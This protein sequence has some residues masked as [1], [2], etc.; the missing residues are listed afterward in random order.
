MSVEAVN[1]VEDRLCVA[2]IAGAHGVRGDVRIKSFT[3]N[4]EGLAAYDG[5]TIFVSHEPFASAERMKESVTR[6]E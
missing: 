4:P 1:M 2:V 3:A 5:T 6:T